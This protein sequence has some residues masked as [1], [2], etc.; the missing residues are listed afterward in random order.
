MMGGPNLKGGVGPAK[1]VGVTK[2]DEMDEEIESLMPNAPVQKPSS[3]LNQGMAVPAKRVEQKKPLM[4]PGLV[5]S[6]KVKDKQ[7]GPAMI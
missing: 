7:L 5:A 3:S 4:G 6:G 1:R 2:H